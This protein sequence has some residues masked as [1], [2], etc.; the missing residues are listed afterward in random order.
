[1]STL[2]RM[3]RNQCGG[4]CNDLGAYY[5]ELTNFHHILNQVDT[6]IDTNEE[7]NILI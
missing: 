7:T 3:E 4:G 1:M 6:M 2:S 5:L